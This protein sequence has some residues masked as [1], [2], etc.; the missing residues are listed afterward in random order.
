MSIRLSLIITFTVSLIGMSQEQIDTAFCAFS[1]AD[2]SAT[3]KYGGVGLTITRSLVRLM[4]DTISINS[5][6]GHGTT[7]LFTSRFHLNLSQPVSQTEAGATCG[8]SSVAPATPA[9]STEENLPA[10]DD[11]SNLKGFR[12][13][14]VDDILRNNKSNHN[15]EWLFY[16]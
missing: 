3:R 1:Q 6:P 7:V 9:A 2:T 8:E 16:V 11:Y 12:V 15:Q 10:P 14:L 4:G 5:E 13:L